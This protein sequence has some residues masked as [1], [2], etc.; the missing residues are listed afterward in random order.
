MPLNMHSQAITQA[1]IKPSC[2]D[3]YCLIN[4]RVIANQQSYVQCTK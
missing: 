2:G 4:A 1:G 3:K